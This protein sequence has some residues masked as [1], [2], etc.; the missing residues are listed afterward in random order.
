MSGRADRTM[1]SGHLRLEA[2]LVEEMNGL[3]VAQAQ[4]LCLEAVVEAD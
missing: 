2:V 4:L 1:G 3:R